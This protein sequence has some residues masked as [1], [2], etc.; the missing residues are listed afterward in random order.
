MK[1][2]LLL[3]LLSIISYGVFADATYTLGLNAGYVFSPQI[4]PRT[5][6]E[7]ADNQFPDGGINLSLRGT[8]ESTAKDSDRFRLGL[9]YAISIYT[10]PFSI[11]NGSFE[12]LTPR[13]QIGGRIG[14]VAGYALIPKRLTVDLAFGYAMLMQAEKFSNGQMNSALLYGGFLDAVASQR[15]GVVGFNIG[16]GLDC[17]PFYSATIQNHEVDTEYG[18]FGAYAHAGVAFYIE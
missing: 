10:F 7:L 5:E 4:L 16:I 18:M 8:I 13:E 12:F 14:M 15:F 11:G 1:R 3:V 6:N 17:F 2:I 9:D